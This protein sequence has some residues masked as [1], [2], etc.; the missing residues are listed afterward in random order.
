VVSLSNTDADFIVK[1]IDVFPNNT[2]VNPATNYSMG[3]YQML[4]RAEIMRGK[5]RNSFE[6]PEPFVPNKS[7]QVKYT[8]PDVA[9]TFKKGHKLMIQ[10]QSSWFPLTDLN[11]QKFVENINKATNADFVKE[12]IKVYHNSSRIILP[13][14]K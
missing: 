12:T 1:L 8:M 5:F 2:P 10:V 14:I 13:V 4:V 6:K 9:H 7:T 11:P 3:G